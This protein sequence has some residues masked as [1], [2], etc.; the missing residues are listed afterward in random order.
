[1]FLAHDNY[2]VTYLAMTKR[3]GYTGSAAR[4]SDPFTCTFS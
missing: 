3:C 1:M 4:N 2:L